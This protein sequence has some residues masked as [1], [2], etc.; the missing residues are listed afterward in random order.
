MF[1]RKE[2]RRMKES[3]EGRQSLTK[4]ECFNIECG[5][6]WSGGIFMSDRSFRLHSVS[7]MHLP[8]DIQIVGKNLWLWTD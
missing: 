6:N 5:R 7:Q 1:Q 4:V 2:V 3:R 8:F